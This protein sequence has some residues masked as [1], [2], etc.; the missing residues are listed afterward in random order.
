MGRVIHVCWD[1]L[2]DPKIKQRDQFPER[3]PLAIDQ[4]HCLDCLNWWY[5]KNAK[6]DNWIKKWHIPAIWVTKKNR[7]CIK[8]KCQQFRMWFISKTLLSLQRLFSSIQSAVEKK[9]QKGFSPHKE[10][11]VQTDYWHSKQTYTQDKIIGLREL[12]QLFLPHLR[13]ANIKGS[14]HFQT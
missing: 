2:H 13:L 4:P 8:C 6:V 14:S 3:S 10:F 12:L 9:I 1:F 5:G 11:F 7:S